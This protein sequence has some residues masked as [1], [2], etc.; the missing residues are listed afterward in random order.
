MP[1][2]RSMSASSLLA[3]LIDGPARPLHVLHRGRLAAQL[4]DETG[5]VV[6]CVTLPGA[7]RLP[8]ACAVTSPAVASASFLVGDGILTWGDDTFSVS[9]WWRPARPRHQR[10]RAA[11]DPG[12]A[13]TFTTS[14]PRLLGRG[15]GLTP[16]GDDVICGAL[17]ALHAV[18]HPGLGSL[19]ER[20]R[21][22]D[23]EHMTTATSAALLRAACDG[24]CID[25]L[26]SYLR[27]AAD[28]ADFTNARRTV[29]AVG[30][31][32]GR[33]LVE[34]VTQMLPDLERLAA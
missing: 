11:L 7:V 34:G 6:A 21:A 17:V 5:R 33:G 22:A 9:R 31:S 14:W 1:T 15:A 10:L 23:L 27:A 32:S 2:L 30:S 24:W 26:G 8:Y 3:P 18:D 16:Y 12:A 28:R 4:C 25:E 13:A 20:I 29:M 19:T